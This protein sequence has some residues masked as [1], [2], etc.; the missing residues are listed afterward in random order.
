M[1]P[2]NGFV[3]RHG[4]RALIICESTN[5]KWDIVCDDGEWQGDFSDC[6]ESKISHAILR[7]L[8][9]QNVKIS[10]KYLLH[11]CNF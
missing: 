10:T 2:T 1:P 4:D 8:L 9:E 11:I 7:F 3:E 5:T 6:P